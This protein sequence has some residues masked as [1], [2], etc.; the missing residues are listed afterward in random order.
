M[1]STITSEVRAGIPY[2][3]VRPLREES[4]SPRATSRRI[5]ALAPSDVTSKSASSL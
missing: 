3:V 4:S 5:A 2:A 1:R